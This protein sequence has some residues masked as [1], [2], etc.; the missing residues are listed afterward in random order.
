[1][2]KEQCNTLSTSIDMLI[3]E[4]L[5]IE[6]RLEELSGLPFGIVDDN[7]VDYLRFEKHAIDHAI[8]S[9]EHLV[10]TYGNNRVFAS[11]NA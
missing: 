5:R 2:N 7:E 8:H 9:L 4:K 3:S 11:M 6:T 10:D 1:M